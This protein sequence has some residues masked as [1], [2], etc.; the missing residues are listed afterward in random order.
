MDKIEKLLTEEFTEEFNEDID[1]FALYRKQKDKE[2]LR[3][4]QK[5]FTKPF[6]I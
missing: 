6:K 4:L 2:E 3:S 5:Q 1:Y